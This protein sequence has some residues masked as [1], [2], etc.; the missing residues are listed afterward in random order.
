M[1]IVNAAVVSDLTE[2]P[3][4]MV[5]HGIRDTI[6]PETGFDSLSKKTFP[7]WITQISSFSK[8][9]M[10]KVAAQFSQRGLDIE[11]YI[12]ETNVTTMSYSDLMN[13]VS[14]AEE[15]KKEPL[16]VLIDTEGLDCDIVEGIS[17]DSPFLPKYLIFEHKHCKSEN[18][19]KHLQ[20]MGY[21]VHK[22]K[23]NVIAVRQSPS[24]TTT[25][26]R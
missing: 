8:R 6:D 9:T 18:A 11:D 5:F 21:V 13:Q 3:G 26:V 12:I 22:L 16:I 14:H 4:E 19:E 24:N 15:D 2:N 17:P 1:N 23:E 10:L 25:M 20:K 7:Y